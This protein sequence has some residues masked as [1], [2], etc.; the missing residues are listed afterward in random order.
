MTQGLVEAELAVEPPPGAAS[1][2][3][4]AARL[5]PVSMSV[6][7]MGVMAAALLSGSTATRSPMFLAFP[8]VT[9]ASLVMAVASARGA[10]RG[11]DADRAAYLGYL[12]TLRK[13]VAAYADSQCSSLRSRNPDPDTLWTLIGGPRTWERK[14]ADADFC[15]VRFGLGAR[16]LTPRL[17]APD[18]PRPGDPVTAVALRRFLA[19]HSTVLG[20]IVVD[21][22]AAETITI[23]GRGAEARALARAVICQLAVSHPPDLVL[24]VGVIGERN[25][26]HWDWL[27]W[28]PHNGHPAV[29]DEA[30][31][32]RMVYRTMAE[33]R[34]AL[35][36]REA[37]HVL[38]V[39]DVDEPVGAMP[40][41]SV[42]ALRAREGGAPLTIRAEEGEC[43]VS[44]P[45]R[46]D[47][48]DALVCARRLAGRRAA[49]AL[50][51]FGDTVVHE[52]LRAP[53]G[54]L[55]DGAPLLLDIKEPSE[56]GM[57]PHGLCIGATGSGKSE[58][59]RTI[60]LG[61]IARNPPEALNLLLVDFKGGATFLDFARAPHVAA[62]IT[63]L[64]DEAPLVAR[65]RDALAGEMDRRQRVLRGVRCASVAAYERA[66]SAGAGWAALPTLLIIVDEFSELLSQQP[67]FV[68]TFVAIGR[69]GRSLGMHLLLSSQR[70]DEGRLRGLDA[71]LSY[72]VCLKTLSAGDSR[73]VLGTLDAYELPTTPGAGFL[74]LGSGELFRF[75]AA[76]LSDAVAVTARAF[77]PGAEAT[78][79]AIPEVRPFST[80]VCGAV[81]RQ[82]P[83]RS[84]S[85]RPLDAA[86][87]RLSVQGPPAHQVWL[88]PL[89][90]P[91]A[92][93]DLLGDAA[94]ARP[95]LT[96]PIGIVDRPREQ[97]RT[98]L[99]VDLSGAAG[100]VAVV[101][102]P[103][104]GKS[105]ALQT[106]ITGLAATHDPTQVQF[107]CLDF[108]GGALRSLRT[109][110]HV[111]AVAGRAEPALVARIVAE[112]E[113]VWRS[114]ELRDERR[115]DQFGD[116]FLVI[117]GWAAL[118]R[119]FAEQEASITDLAARGLSFGVHVV[120]SASRWGE[121]RPA[122]KDQIGTRIELR[123]GDPAESEVDRKRAQQ[124]PADN[125][126]RGLSRDGQHMMIALP[127]DDIPRGDS[128]A[129]P[130]PLLP[131]HVDQHTVVERA[132][133][134]L[135]PRMLI[136]L[137]E[138]RILPLPID[139]D[140][141]PHLLIVGD[142]ECGKS[143]T[144]RTL[145]REVV[146]T[147]TGA[148][149]RLMI[150]DFRRS[151]LGVVDGE[152]LGGYAGSPPALESLLAELL[153]SLRR[154][155]PAGDVSQEQLRARS[156]WSGPEFF[157]VVDDYDLT[158]AAGNPL[159]RVSEFLPHAR[160]VGLHLVVARRSGG[161]ERALFE[162]LLASL[163]DLGC[164][165]LR[166]SLRP[167]AVVPFGSGRPARL[168]PG[169]GL[170]S[171]RPGDEQ[172][173]Q[174]GWTPP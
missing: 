160:D 155:T 80:R 156:W 70:L 100:N 93:R 118:R 1:G 64:A 168:P 16:P 107:Y 21:L 63:N 144:L 115:A 150:V 94:V 46:L 51:A 28:L 165:T 54:T 106:L 48:L 149:A 72:R 151:L 169:R 127:A 31:P 173:V 129:P 130:I 172:L 40:G 87:D 35:A 45:D 20:P 146:R 152:H 131:A 11:V 19:A 133:V 125:P 62:V 3:R 58:L 76:S 112:C 117:D 101:G 147:R 47:L 23:D 74:R 18:I 88:P 99:V 123:L 136:G 86:L 78:S 9:L 139:F 22:R 8:V 55:V 141:N 137:E 27:K 108:G 116:V 158:A 14:A 68:E 2:H 66:R 41:A 159:A 75:Q 39:A 102:A 163:R 59:L 174:V 32:A 134:E 104:S 30:G 145:C 154:R 85:P 57:G 164:M 61:L 83:E 52:P 82:Q 56:G 4:S 110:P 81:T 38:V 37:S 96:V 34:R 26:A 17:V 161:A 84:S 77:G 36:L 143:A 15:H 95:G 103:R 67:E 105:T 25:R 128:A 79:G 42:L 140:R 148:E 24:I 138:R 121:I 97:R 10:G 171:T 142:N 162:P 91:P 166:M 44:R 157:L 73:S 7:S 170:L 65:M 89:G 135:G 113:S 119:D 132:G 29:V 114:R 92:L 98:Q 53:L 49:G 71:H 12:A 122:L 167:D 109:V 60:A 111:G 43:E 6:A 13:R 50:C 120:L 5:L 90:Q 153:D 69:L 124:V 126:G 33:A